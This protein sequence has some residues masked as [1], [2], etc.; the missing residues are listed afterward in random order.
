[1]ESRLG[2]I[3]IWP[4]YILRFLFV[5]TPNPATVRRVAVYF[6]GNGIQYG[7]AAQFFYICNGQA[8]ISV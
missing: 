5:D 2:S 1:M 8:G 4:A 6:Y 3:D 7:T